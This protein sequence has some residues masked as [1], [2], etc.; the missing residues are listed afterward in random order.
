MFKKVLVCLDGSKLS[1]QIIPYIAGE[2]G[3]FGKVVLL[4]VVAVPEIAVPLGI[5]GEPYVPVRTEGM[6]EEHS[7]EVAES[8]AYLEKQAGRLRGKGIDVET[9]VLQGTAGDTI[10]KYARENRIGLIALSTHGHTG[11]RRVVFG[12]TAE[13]VLKNSGLPVLLITPQA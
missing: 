1:E 2:A 6:L 3:C 13:Y 5:P 11:L 8:P 4:R 10:I 9:V 12:S 7:K